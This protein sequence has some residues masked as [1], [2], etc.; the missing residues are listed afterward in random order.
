[1]SKRIADPP[2]G[3]LRSYYNAQL[4]HSQG[5]SKK[6]VTTQVGTEGL[7]RNED[8]GPHKKINAHINR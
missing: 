7:G 5:I 4:S 2:G 3:I 6:I 1:M 8:Q